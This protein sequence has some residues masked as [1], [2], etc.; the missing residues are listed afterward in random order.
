MSR[1]LSL[2]RES[3]TRAAEYRWFASVLIVTPPAAKP[4]LALALLTLGCLLL[5]AVVI[6]IPERVR[7]TG[8]LLPVAG[9]LDVRAPRSGWVEKLR[10]RN[11]MTVTSGQALLWLTEGA[12]AP[13]RQPEHVQRLTSLQ[14]ELRLS[15]LLVDQQVA[16]TG[17]R[18]RLGG[19]RLR[20]LESQ[21]RAARAEFGAHSAQEQL[22]NK[23]V[24]RVAKLA[25]DGLLA[26]DT[27]EDATAA[28]LQARAVSQAAWQRVLALQEEVLTLQQQ[29]ALDVESL[30]SLRTQAEISREAILRDIAASEVHSATV[31][32]AP[33]DGI[34]VGLYV[35]AGSFVQ[36]GQRIMTLH[37]PAAP[38]EARLYVS[39]DN[40]AMIEV[41][42]RVELQLRA[43]PQQLFGTQ[44]A[45]ITS[46]SAAAIPAREASIQISVPGPVFEI[47]AALETTH[48]SARGEAWT[49]PPGTVFAA[50]LLR[51]RWPLYRWFLRA[52]ATEAGHA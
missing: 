35:R 49:L 34:A 45:V 23:R 16:A 41:G 27:A 15:E 3:A 5:A 6:E 52:A 43:Y 9:L 19:R 13:E 26:A 38:L 36:A 30:R 20:L 12:Q 18:Q 51:R 24:Q 33:A 10:V 22:Q 21:L 29:V 46:V 17:M 50:D 40:A 25:A 32:S 4:T 39:A 47:R 31:V 1:R 28:A 42:Q 44:S 37:D 14:H 48:I 7:A 2:F 11:G 8:I